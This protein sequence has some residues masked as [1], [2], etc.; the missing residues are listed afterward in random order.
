MARKNPV[1]RAHSAV[2]H[3]CLAAGHDIVSAKV[4]PVAADAVRSE[5]SIRNILNIPNIRFEPGPRPQTCQ[6]VTSDGAP[7]TFC[8]APVAHAATSFCAHHHARAWYMPLPKLQ[9][10]GPQAREA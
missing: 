9:G 3:V 4:T 8:D 10:G 1:V 7:W 5:T 2:I 6:W